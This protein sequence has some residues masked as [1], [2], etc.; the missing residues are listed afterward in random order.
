M[1]IFEDVLNTSSKNKNYVG[2]TMI[3]IAL[4]NLRKWIQEY[5]YYISEIDK[6]PEDK[7]SAQNRAILKEYVT[8]TKTQTALGKE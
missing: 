5:P 4:K 1:N 8:T 7:I 6:I 2:A 3:Y